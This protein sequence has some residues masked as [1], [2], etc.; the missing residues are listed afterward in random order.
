MYKA[1]DGSALIAIGTPSFRRFYTRN[2]ESGY[3][4]ACC[5]KSMYR[6]F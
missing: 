6:C 5:S 4:K 2:S 3:A 1:L